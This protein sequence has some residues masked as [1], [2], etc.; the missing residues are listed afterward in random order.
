MN[1]L[2]ISVII[3][4]LNEESNIEG[5]VEYCLRANPLEVIVS[6]GG[7]R[8]GTL[9]ILKGIQDVRVL[10]SPRGL[11]VQRDLGIRNASAYSRYIAIVDADDR[12]DEQCLYRLYRDLESTG[13]TA[14]QARHESFSKITGRKMSY[15]E[16]AMLANL[17]VIRGLD[18]LKSRPLEM[19]GRPALYRKDALIEATKGSSNQYTSA[20]E[21]ADLAYNLR[22][23]GG[24]FTI[25]SGVTYRKHLRTFRGLFRRWL[26]YGEGDAKFMRTHPERKRNVIKHLLITYPIERALF[27]AVKSDPAYSPFFVLQGL[28]RFA[29]MLFFLWTRN[30]STQGTPANHQGLIRGRK[31]A[32]E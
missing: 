1:A 32:D 17:R 3:R 21:D 11:A 2:P 4:T 12:L 5:C 7:S 23:N 31:P 27:C 30:P 29:G 26:A 28:T 15:W 19:I 8:D 6:D 16:N 18:E 24:F 25:G 13:A 14:A 10:G 22:K 9:E 20:A